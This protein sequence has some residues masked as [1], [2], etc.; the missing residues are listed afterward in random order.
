[1][2]RERQHRSFI[3]AFLFDSIFK[4]FIQILD[5]ALYNK[6]LLIKI[7]QKEWKIIDNKKLHYFKNEIIDL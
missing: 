6:E 5:E 1:M 4:I 3:K 7:K 2:N